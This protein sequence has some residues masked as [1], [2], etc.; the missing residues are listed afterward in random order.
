MKRKKK[1]RHYVQKN[2]NF[3]CKAI[4]RKPASPEQETIGTFSTLRCLEIFVYKVKK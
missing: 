2:V 4:R 1:I 3:L